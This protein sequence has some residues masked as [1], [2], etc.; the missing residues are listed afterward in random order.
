MTIA[1]KQATIKEDITH[2]LEETWGLTPE[3]TTYNSSLEKPKR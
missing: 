3:E 1:K 2:V